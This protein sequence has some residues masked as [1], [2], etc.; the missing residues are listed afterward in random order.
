MAERTGAEAIVNI[1]KEAGVRTVFG[2]PSIHNIALY[3]VLRS[4]PAI[5]HILCRQEASAT[6]MADGYA[7]QKNHLGVVIASTGPGTC[8]TTPGIL[9]AWCSCSPVLLITTNI[10]LNKIGRG[11]GALHELNDQASLFRNMT[12]AVFEVRS[13]A[14]IEPMTR[15]AT[16]TALSGCPGPVC[17]EVPTDLL[18]GPV[19]KGLEKAVEPAPASAL[20][21]GME[22]ALSRLRKAKQPLIIAGQGAVRAG[23]SAEILSIAES[24]GAPVITATN[25]KG[26]IPEDHPLA[27]GFAGRRGV[28]REVVGACDMVLA[29]GTR[30]R[31]ADAKRRGLVLNDLIH[32][33]WDERWIG[34]NYPAAVALVGDVVAIAQHMAGELAGETPSE[35]RRSWVAD[36]RKTLAA[37]LEDVRKD[38]KEMAYLEAIRNAIPGDGVLVADNTQLAYWAEYFYNSQCP[39]GLA[40]ARGSAVIGYALAAAVGAKLADPKRAIVALIGDGGFLYGAQEL[41]TAVRHGIGFPVVVVND[42]AFG[43]I[44]HL[45]RSYYGNEHES[46]LINPDFVALAHSFNVNGLRVD[47]PPM[48]EAAIQRALGSQGMW[49]IELE[50]DFPEPPFG[51]Y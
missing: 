25:G 27:F 10:P 12:K 43:I 28:V 11:Q 37:E 7:R 14:D 5:R 32:V 36:A 8:Y 22:D 40:A 42:N 45:Q 38:R 51:L 47:T 2:I 33:D 15:E 19:P 21:P 41:A 3:D 34:K 13:S 18:R 26:L 46:R 20:P 1:I 44:A 24:L 6:H 29:I 9:E 39:G 30:L 31:E 48:L 23:I 49:V 35:A 17:L 4:E 50:A 16:R